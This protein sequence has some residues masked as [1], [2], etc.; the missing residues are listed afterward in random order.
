MYLSFSK[1]LNKYYGLV[2]IMKGM[3]VISNSGSSYVDWEGNKLGYLKVWSKDIDLW[4]NRLLPELEKRIK[5]HWD[6]GSS[7]EDDDLV[8][9]E[10]DD[11]ED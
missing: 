3:G 5:I 9:L 7:P 2:E 8:A 1:G 10:E 11:S 4:E 6:Y